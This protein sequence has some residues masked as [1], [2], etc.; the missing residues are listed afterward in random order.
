MAK[1]RNCHEFLRIKMA[2]PSCFPGVP[3]QDTL[4][5]P[6][7]LRNGDHDF[8][9]SV[10]GLDVAKSCCNFAQRVGAVDNGNHVSSS[11]EVGQS[12]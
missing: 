11:D 1:D 10:T 2:L 3:K 7:R 5:H 6:R 9:A 4:G 12:G 8:A